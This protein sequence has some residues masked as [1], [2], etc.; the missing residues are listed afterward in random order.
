VNDGE[1]RFYLREV[2]S[3][4]S[5]PRISGEKIVELEQAKLIERS[6]NPALVIR[7]TNEGAHQKMAARERKSNSTLNLVQTPERPTRRARKS[8]PAP[9]RKKLS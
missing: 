8:R 2:Y 5:A 6:F 9:L 7:L 4:W 1:Q 3:Y